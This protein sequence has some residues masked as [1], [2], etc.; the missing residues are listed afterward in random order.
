MWKADIP[1]IHKV[2][3]LSE[4]REGKDMQKNYNMSVQS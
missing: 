3:P 1:N 2:L 4:V